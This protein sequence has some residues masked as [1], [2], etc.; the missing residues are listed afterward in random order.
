M[1]LNVRQN[2]VIGKA[3]AVVYDTTCQFDSG[4]N[5]GGYGGPNPSI[6]NFVSAI[7]EFTPPGGTTPYDPVDVYP[8]LPNTDGT[9][10]EVTITDLN[11]SEF[12]IGV[13]TIKYT[14]TDSSGNEYSAECKVLNSC[15]VHCCIDEKVKS[16]DPLC[17]PDKFNEIS[18]LER[19]LESAEAA[20]CSGDY[21]EAD[22]IINYVNEQC[23]CC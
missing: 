21:D 5:E 9:G 13:W 14:I 10:F 8:F 15:P 4:Y 6:N 2:V 20:A 18:R 1:A 22:K 3:S 7:V 16:V 11:I 12:A 23:N 19:L 17:E